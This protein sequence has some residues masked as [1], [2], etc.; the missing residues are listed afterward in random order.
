MPF[1]VS[2][3][4]STNSQSCSVAAAPIAATILGRMSCCSQAISVGCRFFS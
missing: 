2:A 4:I 3:R 1:G